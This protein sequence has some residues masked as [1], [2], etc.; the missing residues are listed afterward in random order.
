MRRHFMALAAFLVQTDPP[1]LALRKIV[2]DAHGD[3][4]ADAGK[5]EG[6]H[7]NQ[8]P[9]AQADQRRRVDAVEKLARLFARQHRGLAGFDDVLRT[10]HRMSRI[11][12]DDL[13]GDQPV[14]QHADGGEVLLDR[15]LLEILAKRLDIGRDMQRLDIGDLAD[16]VMVAPGEEPRGRPDNRPC[17]C[18]C[19]R[20][21]AAKNSSK[22][23]VALSPAAAIRAAQNAVAGRDG[24][25]LGLRIAASDYAD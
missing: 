1:A 11:G 17:A 2:L 21:V 25:R 12:R 20:M 6:H 4:R 3:G 18:F 13:A 9:V 16:L 14:E 22:R 10:A 23:R 8:R 15:R 24:E 19:C 7:R 5:G